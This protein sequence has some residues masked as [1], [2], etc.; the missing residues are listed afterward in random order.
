MKL[1]FHLFFISGVFC[2]IFAVFLFNRKDS[3]ASTDYLRELCFREIQVNLT[4]ES[5]LLSDEVSRARESVERGE[6]EGFQSNS[7]IFYIEKGIIDYWTDYRIPYHNIYAAGISKWK[8]SRTT[9][10]VFLI[11]KENFI[12]QNNDAQVIGVIELYRDY[13]LSSIFL[14]TGFNPTIFQDYEITLKSVLEDD[15]LVL[16]VEGV[17]LWKLDVNIGQERMVEVVILWMFLLAIGLLLILTYAI[18]WVLHLNELNRHFSGLLVTTLFLVSFRGVMIVSHFPRAYFDLKLFDPGIYG[19]STVNASFGDLFLNLFCVVL[20]LIHAYWALVHQQVLDYFSELSDRIKPFVSCLAIVLMF[21]VFLF[22]YEL[23][24][25]LFSNS[26]V[27][28]DITERLNSDS[29]ELFYI[30]IYICQFLTIYITGHFVLKLLDTLNYGL[31]KPFLIHLI[32]VIG[33]IYILVN[34]LLGMGEWWLPLM[35]LVY[36]AINYSFKLFTD[37]SNLQYKTYIYLTFGALM[38]SLFVAFVI[39]EISLKKD[40]VRRVLFAEHLTLHNDVQGEYLMSTVANQIKKDVLIARDLNDAF[41]PK[42]GIERR[43][44]DRYFDNYFDK[45]DIHFSYFNR[46][47]SSYFDNTVIGNY[48]EVKSVYQKP[49]F[50]TETENLFFVT[51]F[52]REFFSKYYQFIDIHK[53]EQYIGSILIDYTLKKY[54]AKSILPSLLQLSNKKG[55]QNLDTYNYAVFDRSELQFS[56]GEYNYNSDD[57][58]SFLRDLTTRS[59]D[60]LFQDYFHLMVDGVSHR[61]IVV[62]VENRSIFKVLTNFSFHFLVLIFAALVLLSVNL[63]IHYSAERRTDFSTKIQT[64]LNIATFAPM[65]FLSILVLGLITSSY[66]KDQ[67]MS[68]RNSSE[69][70]SSHVFSHLDDYREGRINQ[71]GFK[72]AVERLSKYS[73][74]DINIYNPNG[75]LMMSSQPLLYEAGVVSNLMN[76]QARAELFNMKHRLLEVQENLGGFVY[77]TVYVALNKRETSEILGVMSIPFFNSES[78]MEKKRISA[79]SIIINVFAVAFVLLLITS[80]FVTKNLTTPLKLIASNLRK[81]ETGGQN[82]PLKWT[83]NDELG[84]LVKEYN[85]MLLKIEESKKTIVKTE[86]E[87]AWKEMAKQVAHEIKNPLTPMKL[88]LQHLQRVLGQENTSHQSITALLEQV[89]TLSEIATSFGAFAKMPIPVME[90]M[91]MTKTVQRILSLYEGDTSF[92]VVADIQKGLRVLGDE[93][94]L[95]RI[96]TNLILNG[97]QSVDGGVR[98]LIKVSLRQDEIDEQ[99]LILSIEDNGSGIPEEI[100]NKVFIP[101]FTTKY[102]GSGIGLAVARNG[103]NQMGGSIWFQT[104]Q[105]KGTTFFIKLKLENQSI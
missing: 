7:T 75:Q 79:L 85:Q 64:Y 26:S 59:N 42:E 35:V 91:D 4:R 66:K 55:Y 57:F 34:V 86:K 76:P 49:E 28:F 19:S 83:S 67:E 71:F 36:L 78:Q 16:V 45:Y 63:L 14:K 80:F 11:C 21:L 15:G 72:E 97:V 12:Y 101:N 3:I 104:E 38:T 2:L 61:T 17:P 74:S 52:K 9:Q 88:K 65:L 98:P 94:L 92:D 53:G 13:Q 6:I 24:E 25:N 58:K 103:I 18:K 43:I 39:T 73:G 40:L 93:K 56:V 48:A 89:D 20:I 87:Q 96:I 90:S 69:I 23:F 70:L 31:I 62:S 5:R 54:I 82:E 8:I 37:F 60:F 51:N 99:S 84:L 30:L 95:G 81:V 10:G 1:K 77:N 29:I 50:V 68:F 46:N 47:G 22:N 44:R 102:S 41:S 32:L 27:N 33:A 100:Q 105:D